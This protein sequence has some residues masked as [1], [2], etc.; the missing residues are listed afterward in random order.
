MSCFKSFLLS[1]ESPQFALDSLRHERV[2]QH[3]DV[4]DC[5]CREPL[6]TFS[7]TVHAPWH[8]GRNREVTNHYHYT[9]H[10]SF[11][12]DYSGKA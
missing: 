6:K 12:R 11:G 4:L 3:V 9:G 1:Q 5:C 2:S 7:F 8:A 10:S